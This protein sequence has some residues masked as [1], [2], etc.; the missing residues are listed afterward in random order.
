M[1]SYHTFCVGAQHG[2]SRNPLK[3]IIAPRPIAWISSK[4]LDGHRN[5][6]PYS[7]FNLINERPPMVMFS[8]VG[9]KDTVRN[10]EES[11]DFAISIV[12]H[13]QA[14]AMNITSDALP[15]ED[16]EF[17]LAG[18]DSH[19]STQISVPGVLGSPAILECRS[20]SINRLQDLQG[21]PI[22]TWVVFAQ[23]LAVSLDKNCIEEGLF[24]TEL[25]NP[26]SRAGYAD[27]YWETTAS[28]KF[29]LSR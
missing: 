23:I 6:A 11:K 2:L 10:I 19:P 14:D 29:L 21:C 17:V 4:S 15:H 22:D 8:S 13:S 24:R 3:S 20:V 1:T 27:E 16:D 5:L 9:Y 26:I 25:A 28:G 12:S 18:V 7:F